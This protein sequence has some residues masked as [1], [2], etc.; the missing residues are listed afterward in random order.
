MADEQPPRGLVGELDLAVAVDGEQGG[1]R[2]VEH[3]LVEAV[4]V[5]QFVALVAQPL[6]RL[7]ERA[8]KLD[9]AAA[10]AAMREALAEIAEPDRVDEAGELHIG[11]LDVPPQQGRGADHEQP[12]DDPRRAQ[13]GPR[14]RAREGEGRR[15]QQPQPPGQAEEEAIAEA[16]HNPCFSIRR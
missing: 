14:E 5:D 11:A 16:L 3:R 12:R 1:R 13:I 8:G 9:E 10:L 7:V 15:D 6:D 4:G 2:V